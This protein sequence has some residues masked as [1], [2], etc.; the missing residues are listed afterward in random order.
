MIPLAFLRQLIDAVARR[1]EQYGG[2]R[3]TESPQDDGDESPATNLV[4]RVEINREIDEFRNEYRSRLPG[5]DSRCDMPRVHVR[6]QSIG[7]D[8]W[9]EGDGVEV[10]R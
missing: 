4:A 1:S 8:E 3:R 7:A 5:W 10:V 6:V 9:M 2:T